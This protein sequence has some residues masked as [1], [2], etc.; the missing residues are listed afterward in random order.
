MFF[1]MHLCHDAS[2]PNAEKLDEWHPALTSE[3]QTVPEHCVLTVLKL[4]LEVTLRQV[5]IL[6]IVRVFILKL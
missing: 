1:K 4:V 3:V 2:H 5:R 6:V